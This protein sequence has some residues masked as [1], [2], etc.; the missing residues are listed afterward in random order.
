M[1]LLLFLN[2]SSPYECYDT[3][4]DTVN[5]E[6]LKLDNDIR[7]DTSKKQQRDSPGRLNMCRWRR[8]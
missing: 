5:R 7:T 8:P 3:G 6:G 4:A 1:E 2:A